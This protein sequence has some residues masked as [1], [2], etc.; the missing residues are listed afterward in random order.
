MRSM[1]N[2]L[3]SNDRV[4]FVIVQ[5][6]EVVLVLLRLAQTPAKNKI[7]LNKKQAISRAVGGRGGGLV[8]WSK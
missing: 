6:S 8:M 1:S 3:L 2:P 7:F 5:Q 4:K